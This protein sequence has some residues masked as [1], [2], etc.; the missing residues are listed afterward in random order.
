VRM[1]KE[2][3]ATEV[4]PTVVLSVRLSEGDKPVSVEVLDL[5]GKERVAY[6][7][8][9]LASHMIHVVAS[10]SEPLSVSMFQKCMMRERAPGTGPSRIEDDGCVSLV[11]REQKSP[12]DTF[13]N[14]YA[15]VFNL[16]HI[17]A[18]AISILQSGR[19]C[20]GGVRHSMTFMK[21]AFGIVGSAKSH[22]IIQEL[23][24]LMDAR[25]HIDVDNQFTGSG[26]FASDKDFMSQEPLFRILN[27]AYD[28]QLVSPHFE[29]FFNRRVPPLPVGMHAVPDD[30]TNLVSDFQPFP[31]PLSP[32]TTTTTTTTTTAT[33]TT[34][35]TT[36]PTVVVAGFVPSVRVIPGFKTSVPRTIAT[37]NRVSEAPVAAHYRR[38]FGA[39]AVTA[40]MLI[41]LRRR[42]G[43]DGFSEWYRDAVRAS[44]L[45]TRDVPNA[46]AAFEKYVAT[47]FPDAEELADRTGATPP[48]VGDHHSGWLVDVP[49]LNP[50]LGE[51]H[52]AKI[53]HA[54][55]AHQ[56]VERYKNKAGDRS[57]LRKRIKKRMIGKGSYLAR[58]ENPALVAEFIATSLLLLK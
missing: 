10:V 46:L 18:H 32:T 22:G 14:D 35:D 2:R 42:L 41:S 56:L 25:F 26:P 45:L 16:L 30:V 52:Y 21:N 48:A 40:P 49:G 47:T 50:K 8:R 37:I 7:L 11:V 20:P 54:Q 34:K 27:L 3:M 29:R 15:I 13:L 58:N 28:T 17:I 51:E 1:I 24:R 53:F 5:P 19:I 44:D 39:P 6:M 23:N 9:N 31:L 12:L 4:G 57:K 38:E 55:N 43:S 33:A 36:L